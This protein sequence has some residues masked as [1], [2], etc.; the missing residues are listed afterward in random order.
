M[1]S[2]GFN[3]AKILDIHR[4]IQQDDIY[5]SGFTNFA[6]GQMKLTTVNRNTNKSLTVD[7]SGTFTKVVANRAVTGVTVSFHVTRS[8]VQNGVNTI[9]RYNS[10]GVLQESFQTQQSTSS[11]NVGS[12]I[13]SAVFDMSTGDYLTFTDQ[14]NTGV[15]N[16][17]V[18]VTCLYQA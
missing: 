15:T 5:I 8:F 13:L 3:M 16:A 9:N 1:K 12:G 7:N 4:I 14:N 6:S 10:S 18:T 11:S 2:W 17:S